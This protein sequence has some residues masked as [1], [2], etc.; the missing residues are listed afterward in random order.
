MS[1]CVCVSYWSLGTTYDVHRKHIM[2]LG[3]RT[4]SHTAMRLPLAVSV[5]HAAFNTADALPP[6]MHLRTGMP[7]KAQV[8]PRAGRLQALGCCWRLRASSRVS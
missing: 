5:P 6:V 1:V 8:A 3:M 2:A 4:T 7:A